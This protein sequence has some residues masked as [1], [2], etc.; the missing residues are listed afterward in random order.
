MA[1]TSHSCCSHKIEH[2]EVKPSEPLLAL[3][4]I[5]PMC[6]GVESDHPGTCPKCGMDLEAVGIPEASQEASEI[7]VLRRRFI[8]SA[9]FMLPVLGLSMGDLI[10]GVHLQNWISGTLN[11][12]LQ[13]LFAS[14]V[15]LGPGRLFFVR[16]WT[17][18]MNR[19]PN[20][21]TLIMLGIGASYLYSVV[22]VLVPQI[23]PD[24][25]RHQGQLA[26]YFESGAV[27]ATLILLGQFL[28]ANARKKTGNALRSLMTLSAKTAWRVGSS[29]DFDHSEEEVPIESIEK[30]DVLRVHPGETI[31]VDGVVIEGEGHVNEAM[32]TGEALPV[33]KQALALVIGATL[34]ETGSFLMEAQNVG[35]HT[36]LSQMIRLV[37]QAQRS[38][39]PIQALADQISKFF[40][41]VILMVAFLTFGMWATWGPE[42]ALAFAFVNSFAV[43]II[44]CPC[45]LGLAT[46]LS[47]IVGMGEG[48]KSGILI[49][50][51]TA[52]EKAE[53][54]TH[55]V[56]DK[57]GTITVGH[58]E[59][60]NIKANQGVDDDDLIRWAAALE[61]HSEHPL[62]RAVVRKF[63]ER[64]FKQKTVLPKV[65]AF[66]SITGCGIQGKIDNGII[67]VGKQ[68]WTESLLD[69]L[70]DELT[71]HALSLQNSGHTV[72]WVSN[73]V[74]VL[75]IL[76]ISDPVKSTTPQAL[77]TLHEEGIQIIMC[78]GDSLKTAES[79][80]QEASLQSFISKTHAEFS[81]E[82][83]L[84]LIK[85]MKAE[86]AVLA[87]AGDGINDA[88]ALAEAHLGI[89]MGTGTDIAIESADV[90]L[91]KGDL[92]GIAKTLKLSRAVMRNI[93]Q[94]LFFAFAYNMIGVPIAAGLLYP[95][96]G[97]LLDPMIAG[98]AM[99]LSSLC[100]V[101]NALRLQTVRL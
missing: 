73:Q 69:S 37:A 28:E 58:P 48:A 53:K 12:W 67:R 2:S 71:A 65:E 33:R 101:T 24:N 85:Q 10:P 76:G 4:Y 29:S 46:P 20:M 27:I 83:K 43:L 36:V 100:V 9:V 15:I 88:P 30:G 63:E 16:G 64:E 38:Q 91:L 97:I 39:P 11:G 52:L 99:A 61:R 86:G 79:V 8:L 41:P 84:L 18:L 95:Q 44:A 56:I 17:S 3:N 66:E 5:C 35:S 60:S 57:T 90:T 1:K 22:A 14:F 40:V 51:A 78:T 47:I 77:K 80:S 89:A 70:P 82:D 49:R 54:V 59:V 81:P 13:L 75:G 23:F 96:F 7:R 34:N 93:R 74:K 50:N 98:G 25:F 68:K 72:I 92:Q 19:S 31:P 32:L 94:N 87:M 21:F 6:P 45:A 26:L 42:P 55:L 62:G